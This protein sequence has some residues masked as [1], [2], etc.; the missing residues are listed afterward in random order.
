MT[1]HFWCIGIVEIN[2]IGFCR[3]FERAS[4]NQN[5]KEISTQKIPNYFTNPYQISPQNPPKKTTPK[6]HTSKKKI[7]YFIEP[8]EQV[9]W[10]PKQNRI[11][12][13]LKIN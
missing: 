13:S 1:D 7:D 10:L 9:L 4:K 8:F 5:P 3:D 6:S 11:D 2:E 12:I